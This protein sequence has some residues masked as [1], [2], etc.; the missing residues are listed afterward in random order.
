MNLKNLTNETL[1]KDTELLVKK[2]RETLTQLLHHFRE[3][4]RRR[5]Y[6]TLKFG[7]LYDYITIKLGYPK[8]QAW[9]RI[10]AMNLLKEI[11]EGSKI[12]TNGSFFLLGK[13]TN[14]GEGH[15]H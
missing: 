15:S 5:L 1:F 10:Q 8:D 3:I 4:E 6:A 13:M 14:E 7:S 11:P 2:E 12:V 9:R